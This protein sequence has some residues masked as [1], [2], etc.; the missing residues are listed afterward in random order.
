[1]HCALISRT[2]A[3]ATLHDAGTFPQVIN[4]VVDLLA[5]VAVVLVAVEAVVAVAWA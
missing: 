3:R 5:L 2:F 1:V 4:A